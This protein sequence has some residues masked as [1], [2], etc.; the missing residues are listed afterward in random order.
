LA[1]ASEHTVE[2]FTAAATARI[3]SKSPGL[4]AREARLDHVYPQALELLADADLLVAGH[5]RAGALLAV[6]NGGVEDDQCVL[7]GC[8]R[9]QDGVIRPATP[10]RRFDC[11]NCG[12]GF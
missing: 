11:A 9:M 7:H 12:W 10:E 3:A 6:A 8:L 1:R 4:E 5:G 2:S